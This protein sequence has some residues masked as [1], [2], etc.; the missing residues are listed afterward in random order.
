MYYFIFEQ[1][2]NNQASRLHEHIRLLLD[3]F[4][5]G[6]VALTVDA[7]GFKTNGFTVTFDIV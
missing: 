2:E 3:D 1:P 6:L 4:N 7:G 5:I